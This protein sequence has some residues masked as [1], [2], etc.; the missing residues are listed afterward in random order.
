VRSVTLNGNLL[1][2]SYL[3]YAEITGG[4]QLS[5]DM[6]DLPMKTP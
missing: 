6:S 5:F 1:D 2:H 3:T 4:R